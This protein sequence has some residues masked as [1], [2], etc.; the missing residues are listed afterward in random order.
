MTRLPTVLTN[1]LILVLFL[2]A[3][4][5]SGFALLTFSFGSGLLGLGLW[6]A[7]ALVFFLKRILEELTRIRC[8][9]EKQVRWHD[10]TMDEL[11]NNLEA[12]SQRDTLERV[13]TL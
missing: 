4:G 2:F 3:F 6:L 12:L 8:L 7:L 11:T 10:E 13:P 1:L 5:S 9:H